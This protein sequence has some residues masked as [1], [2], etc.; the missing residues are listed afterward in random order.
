[1]N[2][3]EDEEKI[4]RKEAIRAIYDTAALD[5]LAGQKLALVDPAD[6]S[7]HIQLRIISSNF[8]IGSDDSAKDCLNFVLAPKFLVISKHLFF[9]GC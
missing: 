9:K 1:M 5:G 7:Y 6:Y 4:V 8:R 2:F 3:L